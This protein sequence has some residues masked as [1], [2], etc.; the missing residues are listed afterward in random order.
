MPDLLD[1]IFFFLNQA[2][3]YLFSEKMAMNRGMKVDSVDTTYYTGPRAMTN[4]SMF[5][6]QGLTKYR[7]KSRLL[8]YSIGVLC[9]NTMNLLIIHQVSPLSVY[10]AFLVSW[11]GQHITK[12]TLWSWRESSKEQPDWSQQ[13]LKR[14]KQL[15]LFSLEQRRIGGDLI[16]VLKILKGVDKVNLNQS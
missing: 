8:E 2:N 16:E 3:M 11:T 7:N 5:I 14:L 4:I 15:N 10:E 13:G 1:T 9:W 12:G 6:F